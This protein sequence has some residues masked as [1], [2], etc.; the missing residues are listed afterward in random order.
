[1]KGVKLYTWSW[2][3]MGLLIAAAVLIRLDADP[4]KST[5]DSTSHGPAG[6][7]AFA[8]L[9]ESNGYHV[10]TD[11]NERPRLAANEVAVAFYVTPDKTSIMDLVEE[12]PEEVM[13]KR[14]FATV[15]DHV[16]KGG[17]A[18]FLGMPHEFKRPPTAPSQVSFRYAFQE[19]K[20]FNVMTDG[21]QDV[22]PLA[23]RA[24]AQTNIVSAPNQ[25]L[26]YGAIA[27]EKAGD[28]GRYLVWKLGDMMSNRYISLAQNADVAVQLV[29]TVAPRGSTLVFTEA[30]WGHGTPESVLDILGPWA[31]VGGRQILVFFLVVI[32]TFGTPFGLPKIARKGE[33]GAKEHIQ[34]VAN[35]LS[36]ARMSKLALESGY[37]DA[38]FKVR[39][40]FRL[41]QEAS[42]KDR[43]ALL[44]V[45]LL[46]SMR[47]VQ[48]LMKADRVSSAD[49][50]NA[51][52]QLEKQLDL[53]A[54]VHK[55]PGQ[56]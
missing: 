51:L 25:N 40:A 50:F 42:E 55:R 41:T 45:D 36:R 28:K 23:S 1:M 53:I 32:W 2:A 22:L 11:F 49:A 52:K 8:E 12:S 44:P 56:A 15:L 10:R 17:S 7:H 26:Y 38:D 39:R 35:L 29:N 24:A 4:T 43:D 46:N 21:P 16:S 54:P 30:S 47:M 14:C 3:L 48:S 27:K 18:I 5:P 37:K 9:M 20:T 31:V 19:P 13:R 34:A 33:F 6:T